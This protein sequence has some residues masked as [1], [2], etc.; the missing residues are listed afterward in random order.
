MERILQVLVRKTVSEAL[1]LYRALP[2]F[3]VEDAT[4]K[5]IVLWAKEA[6]PSDKKIDAGDVTSAISKMLHR[7]PYD[8]Y[9]AVYMRLEEQK[10]SQL[11]LD[12]LMAMANPVDMRTTTYPIC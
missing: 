1:E 2:G 5:Q 8:Q 10:S 11:W 3:S 4:L 12:L 9:S 6:Y 7:I